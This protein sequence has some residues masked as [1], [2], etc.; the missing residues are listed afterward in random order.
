MIN[1]ISKSSI[2]ST[3]SWLIIGKIIGFFG[4]KG[5]LKIFPESDFPDRFT[6]PGLRWIGS[7]TNEIEEVNLLHGRKISNT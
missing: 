2:S 7:E 1:N 6:E 4:I 5:E 3:K